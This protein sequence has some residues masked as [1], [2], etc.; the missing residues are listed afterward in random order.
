[1]KILKTIISS[2]KHT[3]LL[4]LIFLILSITLNYLTTCIPVVIQYLIDN[5]LKQNTQS[6]VLEKIVNI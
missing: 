6:Q 1:M 3:K 2:L 4:I 5:I